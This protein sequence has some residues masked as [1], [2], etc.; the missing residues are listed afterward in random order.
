MLDADEE[1]SVAKRVDLI[2]VR[3]PKR[4]VV[5]D[6]KVF[7][8]CSLVYEWHTLNRFDHVKCYFPF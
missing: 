8:V 1:D 6:S 7:L 2:D 5:N 4:H 3:Y